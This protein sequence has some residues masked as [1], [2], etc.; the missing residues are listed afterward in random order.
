MVSLNE[1]SMAML[2]PAGS[3]KIATGMEQDS[4]F[5]D[6]SSAVKLGKSH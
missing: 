4:S 5:V 6:E 2:L 3:I 1:T